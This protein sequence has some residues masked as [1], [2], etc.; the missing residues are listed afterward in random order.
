M[1]ISLPVTSK[2]TGTPSLKV[3]NMKIR[4]KVTIGLLSSVMCVAALAHAATGYKKTSGPKDGMTFKTKAIG[5]AM[6]IEGTGPRFE[7]A[8]EV[9]GKLVFTVNLFDL[10]TGMEG[11]DAHLQQVLQVKKSKD[12]KYAKLEV[13]VGSVGLGTGKSG[14]GKFTINNKPAQLDF[15]YDAVKKGDKILVH[16]WFPVQLKKHGV[17]KICK[18]GVCVAD[19]TDVDVNFALTPPGE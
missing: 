7:F 8:E 12:F 2:R 14:H 4:S 19:T 17:E 11:R 13:P 5:G 16:A 18:L 3:S 10:K 1:N 6:T 9:K 15:K